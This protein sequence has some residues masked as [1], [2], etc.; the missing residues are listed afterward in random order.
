[1]SENGAVWGPVVC[2]FGWIS[3]STKENDDRVEEVGVRI[4]GKSW[5]WR[6]DVCLLVWSSGAM[7]F[8]F[9]PCPCPCAAVAIKLTG[10]NSSQKL[11]AGKRSGLPDTKTSPS[12]HGF[13]RVEIIGHTQMYACRVSTMVKTIHLFTVPVWGTDQVRWEH[14]YDHSFIPE[15]CHHGPN[16]KLLYIQHSHLLPAGRSTCKTKKRNDARKKNSRQTACKSNRDTIAKQRQKPDKRAVVVKA[17]C[18]NVT[19]AFCSHRPMD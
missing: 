14:G 5:R 15:P 13:I 3:G 17:P 4:R 8:A 9:H 19:R 10:I 12:Q 2:V 18:Q 1:M 16:S 7:S 11:S 6:W